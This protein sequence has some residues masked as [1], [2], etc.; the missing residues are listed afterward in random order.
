MTA[1]RWLTPD[2]APP[3]YQRIKIL[4]VPGGEEWEAIVRGALAPL[5]DAANFEQFGSFTP[6]ETAEKFRIIT[7]QTMAW[8]DAGGTLITGEIRLIP[9]ASV[10]TGWLAC[11]GALLDPTQYP[12][13][14]AQIG[15]AFGGDGVNTFAL[16]DMRGRVAVGVGSGTGLT[17]RAMG[18]TGGEETHI[19]TVPEIPSHHHGVN[20]SIG[21]GGAQLGFA[22]NTVGTATTTIN[23]QDAGGGEGH[24]NMPPF[25]ALDFYIYA[26]GA[27][28]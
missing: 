10:P 2:T 5:F 21:A 26:G 19:L 22:W 24:E 25:V 18:D 14:F 11:N 16:P 17:P 27:A 28:F 15:A 7:G 23:S 13:L 12:D 8:Q 3:T 9:G 6:E 1:N 20:R 4:W